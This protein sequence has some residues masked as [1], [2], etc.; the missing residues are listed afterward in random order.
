[1]EKTYAATITDYHTLAHGSPAPYIRQSVISDLTELL[2][3]TSPSELY[4]TSRGDQA[5]DHSVVFGLTQDAIKHAKLTAQLR[6][7]VI[8]APGWPSPDGATPNTPFADPGTVNG[9]WTTTS[10]PWPP[11]LRIPLTASERSIKSAAI[12]AYKTQETDQ[13]FL[14]SFVKSEEVFWLVSPR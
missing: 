1:M 12:A 5:P 7:Y 10:L 2:Q 4:V 11:P 6:T 3:F 9:I 14:T 13:D 8:H